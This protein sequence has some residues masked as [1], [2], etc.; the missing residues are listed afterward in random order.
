[1]TKIVALDL[2][3]R[4]GWARCSTDPAG[5]IVEHGVAEFPPGKLGTRYR[6]ARQWLIRLLN[7]FAPDIVVKEA[8]FLPM[9]PSSV[10]S[11]EFLSYLHGCVAEVT[12]TLNIPRLVDFSVSEWRN[13]ALGTAKAPKHIP[14][15]QRRKW[16]K[17][18]AIERCAELGWP[19]RS[20]DEAE[21]LLILHAYRIKTDR[22]YAINATPLLRGIR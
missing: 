17:A 2:S 4:T 1:M 8:R 9:G 11:D 12:S 21:A 22:T 15:T 7:E 13:L 6:E 10:Q 20:D 16:W 19:V 5:G 14:S 3:S 18:Q